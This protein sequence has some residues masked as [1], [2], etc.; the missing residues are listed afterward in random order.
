MKAIIAAGLSP[1]DSTVAAIID[2]G[3]ALDGSLPSLLCS[4]PVNDA[5]RIPI[6]LRSLQD[7][8]LAG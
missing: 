2:A 1:T 4:R 8:G 5:R 6:L 7:C 3:V